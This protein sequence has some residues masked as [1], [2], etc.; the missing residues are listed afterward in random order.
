MDWVLTAV[1]NI[2][3][4]NSTQPGW[5]QAAALCHQYPTL[6][7]GMARIMEM[8]PVNVTR[9]PSQC[10]KRSLPAAHLATRS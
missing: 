5:V 6:A 7:M 10:V 8:D 9:W 1:D 4:E 2:D 3:P